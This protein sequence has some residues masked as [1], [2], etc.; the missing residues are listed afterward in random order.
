[1]AF[2]QTWAC[3]AAV[4]LVVTLIVT[5]VTMRRLYSK[6]SKE[7]PKLSKCLK[8]IVILLIPGWIALIYSAPPMFERPIR[9]AGAMVLL[10][11]YPVAYVWQRKY[12][13]RIQTEPAE[14]FSPQERRWWGVHKNMPIK[15]WMVLVIVSLG[16]FMLIS[17]F[18][19]HK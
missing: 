17:T 8:G 3:F 12:L 10:I 6:S 5:H 2:E 19:G 9:Y 16:L 14:S 4:L 15:P 1:M 18:L 7:A 11:G 13:A